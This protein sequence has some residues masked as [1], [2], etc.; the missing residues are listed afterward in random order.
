MLQIL[1]KKEA[2]ASRSKT[3]KEAGV[4]SLIKF[5]G[6]KYGFQSM[7]IF[8]LVAEKHKSPKRLTVIPF[9]ANN[10][11]C[12]ATLDDDGIIKKMINYADLHGGVITFA[13]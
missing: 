10:C 9:T 4:G 7:N 5:N 11:T 3:F 13:E 2:E 8:A 6:R 12:L 1:S